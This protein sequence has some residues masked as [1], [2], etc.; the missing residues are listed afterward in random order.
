MHLNIRKLLN[1][2]QF[3][4]RSPNWYKIR[5]DILTASNIAPILDSNPF[6]NK[7]DLLIQKCKPFELQQVLSN[8]ATMWGIKYEPI[9]IKIYESIKNDKVNEVGLFIHNKYKWLGASP[10]G[11]CDS[12]KLLEIKCV[13]KRKITDDIPLYYWIQVQIQLEVCNLEECDLFQCKFVE[14]KNRH[15]YNNDKTDNSRGKIDGKYWKLDKYTLHTIKRDRVWFKKIC[16]TLKQFW[17]DVIYYRKN[18]YEK[19][20]TYSHIDINRKRKNIDNIENPIPLK[21]TRYINEDWSKWINASDTKNYIMKDPLL[22]WLNM[23]NSE[24]YHHQFSKDNNSFNDYIISKDKAFKNSIIQNL[25]NRFSTSEII[26]IAERSSKTEEKFS[27][28]KYHETVN[29]MTNGVPIILK[30]VLHNSNNMTYGMPDIILRKDYLKKVFKNVLN[31]EDLSKK[32]HINYDYCIINIKYMSLTLRNG[33]IVNT[34][35]IASYKSDVIINNEALKPI[36]GYVPN[37]A[38]IIG[39]KYKDDSICGPFE[40]FGT[41]D[42]SGY[43]NEIYTKTHDAIKWLKDLR[44]YGRDWDI[45]NPHRWELYPNMSNQFDYPWNNLKKN[46]SE[47]IGEITLLWNCGVK[48]RHLAHMNGIYDWQYLNSDIVNFKNKKGEILDNII[49]AN[50]RDNQQIIVGNFTKIKRNKLHFFVDFETVNTS[51]TN[52]DDIVNY[53]PDKH[54]IIDDSSMIYMIGIGWEHPK[55]GEW[56]FKYFV[57]D[58]LNRDC[59]KN[60]ILEWIEYMNKIKRQFRVGNNVKVFHWSKAEVIES[61]KAFIRHNI[62]NTVINWYDLLEYFKNSTIAIKG[63]YNYGLKSIA[64]SLYLHKLIETKWPDSSLDGTSAMLAAWNC[65]EKCVSDSDKLINFPEMNEIV[66]YNEIDCKAIWDIL[67]LFM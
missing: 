13:W 63:V 17:D 53:T 22:D 39:K 52:F 21:K 46:I 47:K 2:T 20:K 29:A 32:S 30:S 16:P 41:I 65:E 38:F 56:M 40:K 35:N 43:D 33:Y 9:A 28:D 12:G 44:E 51:F 61:K 50:L 11:V 26:S 60:I 48:E 19:L 7:L 24:N 18:G 10:D 6:M 59:E 25:H 34:N 42:I 45:Y 66:N 64:N 55:S 62:K 49:D 67:K 4:Q 23:Y 3:K 27:I 36:L 31:V 54:H 57:T 37:T 8:P 14:Y 58:R 15:E 5:Y 1:R